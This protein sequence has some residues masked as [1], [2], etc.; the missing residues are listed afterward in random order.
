VNQ[1]LRLC[2]SNAQCSMEG[3]PLPLT[4]SRGLSPDRRMEGAQGQLVA[5]AFLVRAGERALFELL[6]SVGEARD[7]G[8]V[9]SATLD[10]MPNFYSLFIAVNNPLTSNPYRDSRHSVCRR[11]TPKGGR[12]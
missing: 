7:S 2:A 10:R 12:C 5:Y 4:G 3:P 8:E 11:K 1:S 6:C 9:P